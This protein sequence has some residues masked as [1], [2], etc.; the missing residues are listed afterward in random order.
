MGYYLQSRLFT[1]S[2]DGVDGGLG[3]AF[4]WVCAT[5]SHPL[6]ASDLLT[7]LDFWTN[8]CGVY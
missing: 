8:A 5:R 3:T 1:N 2:Y 4:G 6:L 7:L